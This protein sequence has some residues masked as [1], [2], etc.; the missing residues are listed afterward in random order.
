M[1]FLSS[2]RHTRSL[3]TELRQL[4]CAARARHLVT[5][6]PT[7]AHDR[8]AHAWRCAATRW[9]A[10][11][12]HGAHEPGRSRRRAEHLVSVGAVDSPSAAQLDRQA[13]REQIIRPRAERRTPSSMPRHSDVSSVGCVEHAVALVDES[14]GAGSRSDHDRLPV[15]RA[16]STV[17]FVSVV[18]PTARSQ[19]RT[20]AMFSRETYPTVGRGDRLDSPG[21]LRRRITPMASRNAGRDSGPRRARCPARFASTRRMVPLRRPLDDGGRQRPGGSERRAGPRARRCDRAGSCGR[22]PGFRHLLEQ[23]VR[24]VAAR[25]VAGRDLRRCSSASPDPGDRAVVRAPVDALDRSRVR[26]VDDHDLALRRGVPARAS[27]RRRGAGIARIP[28]TP[29]GSLATRKD[30]AETHVQRLTAPTERE[31][32][33][34]GS[35]AAWRRLARPS[36]RTTRRS[37][38]TPR[39]ARRGRRAGA[40]RARD[41]LGSVVIS[42]GSR[43]TTSSASRSS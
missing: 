37:S 25:D 29:Y 39:R 33:R 23:V 3:V 7:T 32:H 5:P 20:V 21:S 9:P 26:S 16:R 12:E 27:F 28:T 36:P 42:A 34:P 24:H 17:R 31:Q 35:A 22:T 38:E 15:T 11:G 13:E 18:V 1:C 2:S 41:D 4:E 40:R 30:R 10:A 8:A 19:P 14:L 43:H 6:L